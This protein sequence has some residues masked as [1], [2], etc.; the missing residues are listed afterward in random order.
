MVFV[1]R[2][3]PPGAIRQAGRCYSCDCAKTHGEGRRTDR[4]DMLVTLDHRKVR[5]SAFS[6]AVRPLLMISLRRLQNLQPFGRFG[7]GNVS[8]VTIFGIFAHFGAT[9]L[10]KAP[11]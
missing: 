8:P 2:G 10:G 3:L 7:F 4:V 1:F 9:Y 11:P 5:F 6:R